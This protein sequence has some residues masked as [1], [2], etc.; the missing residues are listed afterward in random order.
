MFVAFHFDSLHIDAQTFSTLQEHWVLS[1]GKIV[2]VYITFITYIKKKRSRIKVH[3]K[4]TQYPP[5]SIP[6]EILLKPYRFSCR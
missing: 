6:E 1:M 5:L 3:Y 4:L 2:S